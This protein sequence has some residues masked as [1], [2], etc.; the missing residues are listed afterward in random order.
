M[1]KSLIFGGIVSCIPLFALDGEEVFSIVIKSLI[2]IFI[3]LFVINI[4]FL[5]SQYLFSKSMQLNNKTKEISNIWIW[6]QLIPLWNFIAILFTLIK[7]DEHYNEYILENNLLNSSSII[8]YNKTW[9]WIWY[10]GSILTFI[11]PFA[12]LVS[13]IGLIGFWIHI[14]KVRKSL[15][16]IKN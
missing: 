5:R 10:I 11:I 1:K 13:L 16:S 8:Q 12:G 3:V 2:G 9:G 6:T 4:F 7:L 15:Q 14:S